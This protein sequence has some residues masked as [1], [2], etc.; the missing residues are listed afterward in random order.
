MDVLEAVTASS[1]LVV[2]ACVNVLLPLT[3]TI[4]VTNCC[5]RL[6]TLGVPADVDWDRSFDVVPVGGGVVLAASCAIDDVSDTDD[7]GVVEGSDEGDGDEEL[8][9]EL[10]ELSVGELD[11]ATEE[12]SSVDEG[13]G[14]PLV[15]GELSEFE[16]AA[17][18]LLA[19]GVTPVP[20]GT[21]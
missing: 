17:T 13:S 10:S 3:I 7:V 8:S 21:F 19:D 5:V 4:V 11:V 18:R 12:E 1:L 9:I 14:E 2:T 15:I 20:T 6:V 16:V